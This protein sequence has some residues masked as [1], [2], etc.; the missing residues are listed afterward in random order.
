[1]TSNLLTLKH[2]LYLKIRSTKS[3][4]AEVLWGFGSDKLILE[5]A[6]SFCDLFPM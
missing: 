4:L 3:E 1:M 5:L 2:L 6:V